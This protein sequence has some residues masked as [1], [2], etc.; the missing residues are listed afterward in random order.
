ML[1]AYL[2]Y[3]FAS[4][5]VLIYFY[6]NNKYK[7]WK[8]KNIAGPEPEFLFGNLK[9]SFHRRKHIA[10]V[11][12]E[13]YDQYPDEK[14]V[15]MFRM[16]SPTLIV[17]DLDIVKQIMI[18]D[19]AKFN[20]RGIKFS[21]EGLG[22]NLFHADADAWKAVRSHL[23]PMFSSG[24]LKNMVR[25]LS[26]TGDRFVDHVT[27]GV[28]LRPEQELVSLFLKYNIATIM[29]CSFSMETDIND[30]QVYEML[31]VAVFEN[32]Y[33]S[34]LDMVF[35]G[36]LRKTNRSIFGPTVNN[37]CYEIVEFIK[38]ERNGKPANRNDMM[39]MLLGVNC[40]KLKMKNGSE[41]FVEITEHVMAG[42]V[43]VFFAAGYVNNTITLTFSL[44]H[45]AKDQ[46]IQERLMREIETVL[47]NHNNVLTLE[48]INEMSYLEMI[49]LETL[50]MHPTT[51]TLQR[52][53]L[54]DYTIPGTDI[55]IEKG[56]LVLIPPL[57]F[58]HDEKIYPEPEKFD[59]ERFS[60][61]NHKSRHACAFLSFGIGPRTCIGIRLAK[62][63]YKVC[64]VKFLTKYRVA[65][66]TRTKDAYKIDPLRTALE[67]EGGVYVDILPRS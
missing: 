8:N 24:K 40:D 26:Q 62:L 49:F 59:P 29:A 53:A 28:R 46:S 45:L 17:R 61:E 43:F 51:N 9:E 41:D 42:Q 23:T 55:E 67:P 14:V 7:Y 44:Y 54:E 52:S 13:I 1:T 65:P 30:M 39:D 50:R 15:G 2:L 4:I 21:K 47:E 22:D 25:V 19:Y 16:T 48:A 32:S 27:N 18:K 31:N 58:H 33:I 34:E 12:K 35:P 3:V 10:T 57:A 56:T 63:Q 60:V 66:S 11:F 37:F 6:L 20:E 5:V 64:M 36:I 38:N